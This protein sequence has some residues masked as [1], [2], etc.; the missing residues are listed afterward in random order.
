MNVGALLIIWTILSITP[1]LP[2]S[3]VVQRV[4]DGDTIV[5]AGGER[6]RYI[7]ID[8]PETWHPKKAFE[9]YGQEASEANRR[10][11][12]G[13]MVRLEYDVQKLD[14]YQRLLAYVWVD[15]TFINA[16]LVSEG[17][18]KV[19]TVPPNVKYAGF[20]VGLQ[21][22]ARERERG[23]WGIVSSIDTLRKRR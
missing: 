22:G 11:V 10:L 3:V 9:E 4:I 23:L 8:T 15:T 18:A 2:D 16:W 17:Y 5:L 21:R 20:L 14:R 19:M 7:G 1:D 12:E 6:V 13:K